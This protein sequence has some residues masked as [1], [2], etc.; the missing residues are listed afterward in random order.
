MKPR[1]MA[2][3]LLLSTHPMSDSSRFDVSVILPFG[4][5]EEFV[6]LGVRRTAEHLRAL[7]PGR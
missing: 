4:D 5:D 1:P 7:G 2:A 6:G 3:R